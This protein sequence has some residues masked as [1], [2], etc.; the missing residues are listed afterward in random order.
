[1]LKYAKKSDEQPESPEPKM[2]QED[3]DVDMASDEKEDFLLC[4]KCLKL[5][6]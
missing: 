6:Q 1:M 3:S 2:T 5:S 4:E